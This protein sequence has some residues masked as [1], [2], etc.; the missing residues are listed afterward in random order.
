M[1]LNDYY[2]YEIRSINS[3]GSLS[4]HCHLPGRGAAVENVEHV[5]TCPATASVRVDSLNE[6]SEI[7]TTSTSGVNFLEMSQNSSRFTQFLLDCTSDNL[8][9]QHRMKKNDEN[10]E[11]IFIKSRRLINSTHMERLRLLKSTIN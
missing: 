7:V 6:I 1:L 10:L 5:L 3:N 11:N 4:P 8:E 2:T 9:Y